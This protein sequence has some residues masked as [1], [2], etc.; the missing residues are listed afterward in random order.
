MMQIAQPSN[1]VASSFV[2]SHAPGQNQ[3][4]H[5]QF[6]Q[7]QT[8]VFARSLY[9]HFLNCKVL[10]DGVGM[11][12]LVAELKDCWLEAKGEARQAAERRWVACHAAV[13]SH[14]PEAASAR[15]AAVAYELYSKARH[16]EAYLVYRD[17][18]RILQS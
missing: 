9:Q 10:S 16:D 13:Y 5:N 6:E 18:S 2:S 1:Y 8:E 4:E 7:N 11:S 12:G 17:S 3:L 14:D 15:A